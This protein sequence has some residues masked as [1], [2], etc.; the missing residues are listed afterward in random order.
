MV[1]FDFLK[2]VGATTEAVAVLNDQ[3]N[4]FTNL[5]VVLIGLG[6]EAGLLT[7]IH[8]A[9]LKPEQKKKKKE[10][11][12]DTKGGAASRGGQDNARR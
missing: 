10:K 3:P 1:N 9:T 4:L 2:S 12:K 7:Y 6:L 5:V 11:K 8:F